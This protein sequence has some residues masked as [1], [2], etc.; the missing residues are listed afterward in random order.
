[1]FEALESRELFSTTLTATDAPATEPAAESP[2][3]VMERDA[4][5]GLATGKRQHAPIRLTVVV[6]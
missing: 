4:A 6:D 2:T 1:M 5:S 3:I